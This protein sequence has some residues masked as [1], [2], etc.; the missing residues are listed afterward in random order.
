MTQITKWPKEN[1]ND[2]IG[3]ATT[4]GRILDLSVNGRLAAGR[5]LVLSTWIG[6]TVLTRL[7]PLAG[8]TDWRLGGSPGATRTVSR[9]PTPASRRPAL[10]CAAVTVAR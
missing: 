7:P 4:S 6:G 10:Q 5:P 2:A 8:P 3:I 9:T 1:R